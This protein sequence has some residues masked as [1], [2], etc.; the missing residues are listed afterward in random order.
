MH[1]LMRAC[2][3]W[4]G[5]S[6]CVAETEVDEAAGAGEGIEACNNGDAGDA[7][8]HADAIVDASTPDADAS[9]PTRSQGIW[10]SREEVRALPMSGP[11]W[12]ALLAAANRSAGT[13]QLS[14]Q[15]QSN[16][17]IVLAK[18]LV[19]ARTGEERYRTEVRQNCMA[20]IDTE[21]GGRTL[22]LGR[23]LAAY[24]FAA[25]LVGLTADED[26]RFRTWLRRTLTETMDDGRTL[27]E[28]HERRPN[29]WGTHA[30]A[31]RVAVAAYLGDRAQIERAAVVFRGWLGDRA[32]YSS[33]D[34][35][36][37]S[38]QANR[39]APV[40]I[41]PRGST[42]SGVSVDGA[43]PEEMR[44]GCEFRTP[45]CETGYAWEALQGA[46]VQAELLYRQGYDV[47]AWQ[48]RALLRSVQYLESIDRSYGGWWADGDDTWL[49]FIVNKRYGTR[50]ATQTPSQAGKNAGY[51][52]WTHQ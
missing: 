48:D 45:P 2:V 31:S 11:A 49:P 18:A 25:D 8:T 10:I 24:V 4:A 36:D 32:A 17:V 19:F 50:F 41:N 44:R 39:S 16:N 28:T 13:P 29:N 5:L 51:A 3:L 7:S 37:L 6:A 40:G 15:D 33:F 9:T 20:A 14:N 23:E 52:D 47:Y 34:F 43:Q 26:T 21:R 27:I 12:T 42:I 1:K 35:G 38:W 22:A 30:G 46:F